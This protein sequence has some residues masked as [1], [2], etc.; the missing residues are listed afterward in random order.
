MNCKIYE[1]EVK[2]GILLARESLNKT[3][4]SARN[5]GF[6]G[7]VIC[8]SQKWLPF[9]VQFSFY[10]SGFAKQLVLIFVPWDMQERTF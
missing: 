3:S 2:K 1:D 10:L 8:Q 9:S 7:L 5:V 6:E 4:Y